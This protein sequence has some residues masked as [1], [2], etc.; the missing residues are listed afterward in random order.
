MSKHVSILLGG[1]SSE[2]AVSLSSGL[3][4]ANALVEAGYRVSVIDHHGG[5]RDLIDALEPRP[6]AVFNALHG[7]GGEDGRIQAVL[8]HLEIPYTHS[9]VAASALAMNKA[10]SKQ[11]FAGLGLHCPE[12]LLIDIRQLALGDPLPRP[13]IVKPNAEGSSVGVTILRAEDNARFDVSGWSYG[14]EALVERYIPGREITV[15]VMGQG[16]D[17]RALG[18]TEIRPN[19]RFYDYTAKYTDDQAIHLV[20]APIHADVA[21][22]ACAWAVAAHRGLG[23]RGVSRADFRYDDTDGEPGQ[24]YLLEV[25]TQ[26][27][28][29]PLSL[30]PEQAAAAGMPFPALVSW[31]VEAAQ[32]GD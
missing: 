32:W 26:P 12:G 9:G 2:R 18:V 4:V 27:G 6:D 3:G 7:R 11:L 1:T 17:A 8:D 13:Y 5:L 15:A 21:E 28:M 16:S 29:T 30:V 24:L 25:N 20:P 19:G 14:P 31:M 22:Q 23:C 10:R